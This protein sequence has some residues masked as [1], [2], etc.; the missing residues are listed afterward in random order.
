MYFRDFQT[1]SVCEH[2]FARCS[3]LN[4]QSF[5]RR[6]DQTRLLPT[7]ALHRWV[8]HAGGDEVLSLSARC[9][10]TRDYRG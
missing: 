4:D 1:P 3:E 10:S 8:Q 7:R 9:M 6:R 5:V 2:I